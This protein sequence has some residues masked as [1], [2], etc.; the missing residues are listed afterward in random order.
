MRGKIVKGIAGF[1]YVH[2]EISRVYA[3]RARGVF[4]NR[5]IKPLVGDDVEFEILD[6]AEGTG[7]VA[8]V[9]ERKNALIRPAVANIDQAMLVFAAA[10]PVPNLNLLDRFLV[11]MEAQKI[12]AVI[13][14]NKKE[15][16]SDEE[17]VRLSD[18]YRRAGYEV[19]L[20]SALHGDGICELR[21]LLR[22]KT[23]ALAGPSGVGKSTL[24]NLLQPEAGMETGAISEKIRRGRH[25]TRHSELFFVERETFLMDT[26]GFSTVFVQNLEPEELGAC[27]PEFAGYTRGC[28]FLGCVHMGERECG[29]KAAAAGGE[30][31]ASRYEN[32]RLIYEELKEMRRY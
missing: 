10:D 16:V 9:L 20:S 32:Y 6:E 28:R 29:V 18:I 15:L 4:R 25:T 24:T 22:G 1:Y 17:A 13:C 7:N 26:P 11:S 21:S 2:D 30:I 14:F 3:C 31:P 23:T 5:K 19:H 12:P 8:E 27:F